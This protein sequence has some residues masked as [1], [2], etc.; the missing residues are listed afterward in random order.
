MRGGLRETMAIVRA[1]LVKDMIRR[2]FERGH[3]SMAYVHAVAKV[4]AILAV[5]GPVGRM[6]SMAHRKG[7]EIWV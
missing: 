6:V 3:A 4:V 7:T 5:T 1:G 2:L